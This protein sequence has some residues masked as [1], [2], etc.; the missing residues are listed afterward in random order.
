MLTIQNAID[1]A[2]VTSGSTRFSAVYN[3]AT[4]EQIAKLPLSAKTE[5]DAAVAVATRELE[6][7]G[8][9][10]CTPLLA[11]VEEGVAGHVG[12][13]IAL[14]NKPKAAPAPR[15][16]QPSVDAG[17]RGASDQWRLRTDMAHGVSSATAQHMW[18][19]SG[20]GHRSNLEFVR[21]AS[22]QR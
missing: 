20:V 4:G 14:K 7:A 13:T 2:K 1:G 11:V 6:A 5:V 22:W 19:G 9:D 21:V 3:P 18:R 8:A 10:I 12:R 16:R 17:A 15:R